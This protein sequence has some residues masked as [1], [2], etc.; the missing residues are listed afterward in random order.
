MSESEDL[1]SI[2][3]EWLE[4]VVLVVDV[5]SS[6]NLLRESVSL[7]EEFFSGNDILLE[8]LSEENV[9]DFDIMCRESVMEE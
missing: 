1:D 7:L 8:H 3:F 5:L 6:L 9:V 2:V 4:H